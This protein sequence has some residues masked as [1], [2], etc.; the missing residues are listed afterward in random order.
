MIAKT[1]CL[2]FMRRM[3][4]SKRF[5]ASVTGTYWSTRGITPSFLACIMAII[6]ALAPPGK[7]EFSRIS[8]SNFLKNCKVPYDGCLLLCSEPWEFL[9][10]RQ[11]PRAWAKGKGLVEMADIFI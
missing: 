5:F 9:Y 3:I 1:S 11:S 4:S 6:L 10:G 7:R 2:V 8:H